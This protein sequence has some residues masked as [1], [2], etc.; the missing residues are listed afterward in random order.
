[1][2]MSALSLRLP[3]SLHARLREVARREGVSI[4][5]LITTAVAG[6]MSA[7]LTEDHLEAR[8]RRGNRARFLAALARVPA[9]EPPPVDRLPAAPP[10]KA[11]R[12]GSTA[13]PTLR[14]I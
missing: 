6:K 14:S 8:A 9:V 10:R 7:L 3:H 4:N 12:R 1:M 13:G 5:Q 2:F 11:A